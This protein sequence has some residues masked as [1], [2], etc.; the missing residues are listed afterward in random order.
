MNTRKLLAT[1]LCVLLSG[2]A[3][4]HAALAQD[5]KASATEDARIARLVALA[6]VWGVVKYFHPALAYREIDW[7]KALVEAVPR[8]NAAKTAQDY[9]GAVNQMLS[10]LNDRSTRAEL[11]TQ[12]S[13]PNPA[14]SDPSKYVRTENRI[15]I[16]DATQI[17]R[18]VAQ[19]STMLGGF[20]ASINQALPN[21]SGVVIDWRAP[22]SLDEFEAYYFDL[23]MRQTLT[24]MLDTTVV[25]G[26]LRHRMHNGYPTQT[27]TGFSYYYSAL[28]STSPQTID[29]RGKSKAPPIAFIVNQNSPAFAEIA[30]GLQAANRAVVIQEGDRPQ[31]FSSGIYTIDLP[32]KVKVRIRTVELVNPDGSIDLQPDAVVPKNASDDAAMKE[33]LR[34]VQENRMAQRPSRP[35]ASP[36]QVSQRDKPYSEMRF[37][38]VEYRLLALFRFWNVVNYFFLINI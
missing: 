11:E 26:S 36:L 4:S 23:L 22:R 27:A 20:V 35:P 13:D 3:H 8:V 9:E 29:G 15:L 2:S 21:V 14:P 25:L 1:F 12:G 17:V 7:D 37:P 32:D 10:V 18:V 19:N 31:D 5:V 24:G 34:A 38:S 33:A 6:K 30:S 16:I 28:V